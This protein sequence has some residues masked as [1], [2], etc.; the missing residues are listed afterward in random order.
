LSERAFLLPEAKR[1]ATDAIRTIESQT[2][3]EI[4]VSMRRRAERHLA[5]SLAFGATTALVALIVMMVS[6]QLYDV[7]TMPLDAVLAFVLAA[8]ACGSVPPLA[9]LLT[10]R[11]R[12]RAAA[13]RAARTAFVA[14]GV[15]RT[16][17]RSGVLVYVALFER[18]A[19]VVADDGVPVDL[20]GEPWGVRLEELARSVERLDFEAFTRTL[21]EFGP[22]LAS[23]LPR[24][25]DDENELRDE[26]A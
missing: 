8:L 24:R 12:R 26:V 23:V 4:V 2:S 1:R 3:A 6:P 22:L 20:L 17:R 11:K 15:G 13:E 7:R 19:V 16:K 21:E 9:R 14:L 18:T 5:T 25:L 10:S